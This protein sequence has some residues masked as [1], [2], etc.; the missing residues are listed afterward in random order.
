METK[1]CTKCSK[2]INKNLRVCPKCGAK[3]PEPVWATA[4]VVFFA[5]VVI[6]GGLNDFEDK[7]TLKTSDEKTTETVS[8]AEEKDDTKKTTV[9]E[10]KRSFKVGEVLETQG[11]KIAFDSNNLNFTN[12][13]QYASVKDGYKIVEFKFTA[14]NIGERDRSFNYYDF[15]C[16]A[17]DQKMQQFYSTDD[18]GLDSGGTISSGKKASVPVYCEVPTNASKITV[19]YQPLLSDKHYEFVAS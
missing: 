5:F 1:K 2:S 17:D 11:L 14:E 8:A 19:E 13:S 16:Y 15:N 9:E 6:F 18:S 10:E 4:L 12:Y 3:Q 7:D